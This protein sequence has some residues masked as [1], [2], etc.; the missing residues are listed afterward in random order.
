MKVKNW[1]E[2]FLIA[3]FGLQAGT[4][5]FDEFYFHRKRG[6]PQWERIGHPIDTFFVLLG[7]VF[8][9]ATVPSDQNLL[10]YALLVTFSCVLIT[11][12]EFVHKKYCTAMENWLHSL[13]FVLHPLTFISAGY[14]WWNRANVPALAELWPFLQIQVMLTVVFMIYQIFYW[15]VIYATNNK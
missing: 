5:F 12:D 15:N 9:L 8:L 1:S 10:V 13:L 4:M 6:L 2:I 14:I 3:P 11:K 7:Y